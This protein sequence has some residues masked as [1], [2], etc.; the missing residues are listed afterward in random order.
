M[1]SITSPSA[2]CGFDGL[3][4]PPSTETV[5]TLGAAIPRF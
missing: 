1:S 5:L 4:F 3:F 2:P